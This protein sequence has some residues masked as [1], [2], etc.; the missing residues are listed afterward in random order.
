MKGRVYLELAEY[1]GAHVLVASMKG[2]MREE[3][4][5]AVFLHAHGMVAPYELVGQTIMFQATCWFHAQRWLS[6]RINALS[7]TFS[8]GKQ[9]E[10]KEILR[11]DLKKRWL[12]IQNTTTNFW[13]PPVHLAIISAPEAEWLRDFLMILEQ[14][15][16]Q[17]A[18]EL[19]LATMHGEPAKIQVAEHLERIGTRSQDYT[20]VVITRGWW[21]KEWLAWQNDALIAEC[22][23]R[24]PI[25][26]I[27]ATGHTADTSL[28]D[29]IVRYAAKTPSDAAHLII[30]WY[31]QFDARLNE[32]LWTITQKTQSRIDRL[33]D[34]VA[35]L[36]SEI[37]LLSK[38][39]RQT[40]LERVHHYRQSIKAHDPLLQTHRGFAIVRDSTGSILTAERTN[41]LIA[42][43]QLRIEVWWT[44]IDV[45]VK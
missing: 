6:L 13:L 4:L 8:R 20:A 3:E 40:I 30:D 14:S 9:L 33:G 15:P 1:D 5:L 34:E 38:R 27:I 42:W 26:V 25:P 28:L 31:E 22:I 39:Q 16:W 36:R 24:M 37:R 19:Y 23:C 12:Y 2:I 44:N 17:I 7:H 32:L 35:G 43:D 10:Q 41:D 18:W 45:I 11:N 21:A 29:E